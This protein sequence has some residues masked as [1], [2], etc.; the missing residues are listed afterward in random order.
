M[1]QLQGLSLN[2]ITLGTLALCGTGFASSAFAQ[3][4][5]QVRSPSYNFVGLAAEDADVAGA[6]TGF[7]LDGSFE[8]SNRYFISGYG[9]FLDADGIG[10]D[11]PTSFA[12]EGGRY[13]GLGNGLVADFKG[14]LGN[15]DFGAADSNFYGVQAN[16]R[17]RLHMFNLNMIEVNA[18]VG[19]TRYTGFDDTEFEHSYGARAYVT[20]ALAVGVDYV[21]SEFGD[22]WMLT[23]R[24]AW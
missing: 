1:K 21:D 13:F 20:P 23:G 5:D 18:G 8:L 15:V 10:V 3:N 11:D 2:A 22:S 24:Y 12:V 7:K 17:Q 14:R 4:T 19:F 16:L 9:R 6:D